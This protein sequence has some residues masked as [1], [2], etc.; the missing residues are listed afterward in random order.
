MQQA[1]SA[2][3]KLGIVGNAAD[4]FTPDTEARARGTIDFY[5]RSGMVDA[6]VSG[7]CHLGGVDKWAEEAADARGI[8]K[9]I[10][11]PK[12]HTWTGGYKERNLL[13]AADSD[14]VMVVVVAD[15]PASYKGQRFTDCYHCGPRQRHHVKSGACWT[16]YR[17][18]G[19]GKEA[20]WVIL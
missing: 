16:A 12:K 14:L 7:G 20:V 11:L 8:Q 13:I 5:L 2:E 17:A 10:H 6:V 4:K 3:V 9:I 19:L 18:I 15:Y 1:P